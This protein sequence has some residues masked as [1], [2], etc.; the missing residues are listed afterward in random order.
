VDPRYEVSDEGVVRSYADSHGGRSKVPHVLKVHVNNSGYAMVRLRSTDAKFRWVLVA[1]LVLQAF[2]GVTGE[3]VNHINGVRTDNRLTNLEWTTSSANMLHS[4][5]VL[6]RVHPRPW[7][8]KF[9]ALN[10]HSKK[11]AQYRPDGTL[12]RVW[13][14]VQE[15]ARAGFSAG[16]VGSVCRGE[17]RSHKGFIWQYI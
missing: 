15:T 8:G 10:A 9:G 13:D 4:Y 12:V 7:K 1:R 16:N 3:Q 2:T 14:A 6:G 11:V 17:R 5:R